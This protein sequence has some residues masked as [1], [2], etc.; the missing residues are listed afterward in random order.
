MPLDGSGVSSFEALVR[1]RHPERGVLLPAAF[2]PVMEE[3]GSIV[4][5]GEW[6]LDQACHQIAVWHRDRDVRVTVAVNLSHRE[7]WSPALLFVVASAL[8]RHGVP[9]EQL[10]LEIT[11]SV[12]V[13]RPDE[14]RQLL[15]SLHRTG[16]RLHIDDF[17]TGQSSLA[18]LRTLPVDAI[19]L[20]RAFIAD[21]FTMPK[22]R[23]LVQVIFEMGRV[24]GLEVIAECVETQ[25]QASALREMGCVSAQGWLYAHALPA[26][27]ATRI[28]SA[29]V[30]PDGTLSLL[31]HAPSR[32]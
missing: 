12:V 7:F 20:D 21:L 23:E 24:L 8:A 1:W 5:L 27:E 2:L 9:P 29:S 22:T 25:D 10:V 18:A 3:D 13:E 11:E 17:G 26:D 4:R 14:A 31:D 30:T 16:V 15:E 32:T 6:V 28:L 19:K